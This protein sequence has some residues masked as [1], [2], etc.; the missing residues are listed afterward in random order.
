M[1][2]N[3]RNVVISVGGMVGSSGG[4][5]GGPGLARSHSIA[6]AGDKNLQLVSTVISQIS[7]DGHGHHGGHANGKSFRQVK[8]VLCSFCVHIEKLF[9]TVL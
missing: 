5:S 2:V 7:L 8:K 3:L 9:T 1:V 4:G 6:A